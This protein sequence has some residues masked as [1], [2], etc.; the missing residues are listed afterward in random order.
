VSFNYIPGTPPAEPL[1]MTYENGHVHSVTTYNP[2]LSFLNHYDTLFY[3]QQN[4]VTRW[5]T[6]MPR[7]T[8]LDV[9]RFTYDDQLNP[10]YFI[11]DLMAVFNRDYFLW[12]FFLSQHNCTS[13]YYE[14]FDVM[15][16]YENTYDRKNR[17]VKTRFT[18]RNLDQPDSLIFEYMR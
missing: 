14:L 16:N 17:I 6:V 1:M 18:E 10:F 12:Q 8:F 13:K 9:K 2:Y 5:S 4:D 15:V 11:N 3:N 7:S